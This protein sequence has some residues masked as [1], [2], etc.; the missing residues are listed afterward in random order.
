MLLLPS[1][2]Q[3]IM[4]PDSHANNEDMWM[5]GQ[6]SPGNLRLIHNHNWPRPKH[7]LHRQ[8]PFTQKGKGSE[9]SRL[10][11]LC[12]ATCNSMEHS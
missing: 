7:D 4:W 12:T 11:L 1:S 6:G 2:P 10:Q 8:E 5:M 3:A 9:T